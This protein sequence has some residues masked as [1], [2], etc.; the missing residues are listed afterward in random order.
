[1]FFNIFRRYKINVKQETGGTWK[2]WSENIWYDGPA[3][4]I[5]YPKTEEELRAILQDASDRGITVRAAGQKHSQPPQ[6]V[7]DNRARGCCWLPLPRCCKPLTQYVIDMSFYKDILAEENNADG[8]IIVR[9]KVLSRNNLKKDAVV[10]VNAG[11]REDEFDSYVTGEN[12]ALQTVT[13]GGIFSLGGM[14]SNDVHGGSIRRGIFA[15]TCE[16]FSIMTWDGTIIEIHEDDPV[17]E[18]GFK[19]I[20][21][22]RVNLGL[23]GIVTRV[24]VKCDFHPVKQSL[25]GR[26]SFITTSLRQEFVD[27]FLDFVT[28][29][30]LEVF[31]DPYK[32]GF[33]SLMWDLTDQYDDVGTQNEPRPPKDDTEEHALKNHYGAKLNGLLF[34]WSNA[35][36]A[37]IQNLIQCSFA[38]VQLKPSPEL[39]SKA[40]ALAMSNIATLQVNS[41]FQAYSETWL[42][43]ATQAMFMSY[44][45]ELP[46]LGRAGL[47]LTYDLL[48]VVTDRVTMNQNFH[49]AGPMEF[50]FVKAGNSVMSGTYCEDSEEEK[51]FVNLDL[52]G[53][54][55]FCK[56]Q[57]D[58][59][60]YPHK[61]LQFMA[62]VERE[63]YNAGG[64]PH[65]GKMYG[66]FDPNG[67]EGNATP[68]FNE[69]LIA[70]INNRRDER[71]PG[72]RQ[73]FN[74]YRRELDPNNMFLNEYMGLLIA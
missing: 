10:A 64:F 3:N 2:N 58:P 60:N 55:S 13:A 32:G 19:P 74:T 37:P 1:M 59:N 21:F 22:A 43:N 34:T 14:T 67:E 36:F 42:Q 29:D 47:K 17:R 46:D 28:H 53:F 68:P 38:D 20:Q 45:V 56:C 61:L 57:K 62:D 25:E 9:M 41:A 44:F 70:A 66:F 40:L 6:I 33:L 12:L 39:A 51:W 72:A 49:I 52:I 27:Q 11:T 71:A 8:E 16:G 30:R 65:Q 18:D 23:L 7:P 26:M 54:I 15:D 5:K 31:F 50:R 73:A 69:N 63:W 4:Y 35:N 48:Q 24:Y